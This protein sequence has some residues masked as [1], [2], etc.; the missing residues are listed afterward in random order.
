MKYIPTDISSINRFLNCIEILHRI[1]S[2][3]PDE[4]IVFNFHLEPTITILGTNISSDVGL[5]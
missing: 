2:V 1:C 5:T 3:N 4:K